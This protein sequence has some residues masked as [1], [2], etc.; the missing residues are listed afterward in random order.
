MDNDAKEGVNDGSKYQEISKFAGQVQNNSLISVKKETDKASGDNFSSTSSL[1]QIDS[2]EE[3]NVKN[4]S[5]K[6]SNYLI[7]E[8]QQKKNQVAA[9]SDDY[10]RDYYINDMLK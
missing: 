3:L 4:F 9:E 5:G 7:C 1:N 8:D 10:E 6:L 2:D